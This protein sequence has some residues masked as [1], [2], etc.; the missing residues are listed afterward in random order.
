[1]GPRAPTSG[2]VMDTSDVKFSWDKYQ[3]ANPGAPN[4]VYDSISRPARPS[5]R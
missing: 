4:M 2:R 5:N 3:K 1:M